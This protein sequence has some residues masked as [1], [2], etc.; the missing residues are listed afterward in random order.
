MWPSR[1]F[2][3]GAKKFVSNL[4]SH[5]KSILAGTPTSAWSSEI[6][7]YLWNDGDCGAGGGFRSTIQR[8]SAEGD[9]I[10]TRGSDHVGGIRVRVQ[11]PWSAVWLTRYVANSEWR[12]GSVSQSSHPARVT[13]SCFQLLLLDCA[14][15]RIFSGAVCR[16]LI[17]YLHFGLFSSTGV[18]KCTWTVTALVIEIVLKK[19]VQLNILYLPIY[20]CIK[21]HIA[22]ISGVSLLNI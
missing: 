1:G 4:F 22:Y 17:Q 20:F 16:W 6:P 10:G 11:L 18:F 14:A 5:S 13:H 3:W 2:R 15:F 12:V 8:P 19:G 21:R 9:A 7:Q